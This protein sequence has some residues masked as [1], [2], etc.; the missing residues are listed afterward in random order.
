MAPGSLF[1]CQPP[2]AG[3]GR[4]DGKVYPR[5]AG[6]QPDESD[7]S[8][9]D[10]QPWLTVHSSADATTWTAQRPPVT[11]SP[12]SPPRPEGFTG[13]WSRRRRLGGCRA[14]KAF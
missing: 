11:S 6:C 4:G 5:F 8:R 3:G 7:L 14:G 12:P 9:Q 13:R 10:P 1:G 2:P